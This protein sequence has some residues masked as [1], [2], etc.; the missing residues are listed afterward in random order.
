M[1]V[2][3]S[4]LETIGDT[5]LVRV[6]ALSDGDVDVLAKIEGFDPTGSIKGRVAL[7]MI[8]EA[9]RAG[10]LDE[11]TTL[12]EP[13]SGNTGIALA[14]ITRYK[15]YD[16]VFVM[17]ASMSVERVQI[18]KAFGADV[19]LTPEEAGEDGAIEAAR[20]IHERQDGYWMPDQ[21]SNE[22]NVEAHYETTG[23]EIWD[24]TD[25]SI[26]H[27]VSAWGTSGTLMGVGRYLK[28]RDSDIKL[29]GVEPSEDIQGLKNFADGLTPSIYDP[30]IVDQVRGV[31]PDEACQW[32]DRL[33]QEEAMFMGL[34]SG[35][36][37]C[38]A[39]DLAE[40]LDHG[41]IVTTF[42]DFGFKYLSCRP[43]GDDDLLEK[44]TE[45]REGTERRRI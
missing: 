8:E 11:E 35:A 39:A 31:N 17:P 30:D 34:S 29:V 1:D 10:H 38:V 36:N 24:Q 19:V 7:R 26:T 12:L 16:A 18:L 20:E 13:T 43:Y 3:D 15:G 44:V 2:H 22:H 4:V 23:P 28:D 40:E 41:T 21:F 14:M 25:G 32:T 9:E 45:V 27:F 6:E 5:P 37:A 33:A 42:A